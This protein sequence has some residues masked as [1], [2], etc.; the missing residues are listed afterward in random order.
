M[1]H[2]FLNTIFKAITCHQFVNCNS[3]SIQYSY[4]FN[5]HL[6]KGTSISQMYFMVLKYDYWCTIT[7]CTN[8]KHLKEIEISAQ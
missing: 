3:L 1:S 2:F 6:S 7:V 8:K 5:M 4:F